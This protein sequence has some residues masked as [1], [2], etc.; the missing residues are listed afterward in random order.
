[1]RKSASVEIE[2]ARATTCSMAGED[3]GMGSLSA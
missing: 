1:M 3:A 2:K